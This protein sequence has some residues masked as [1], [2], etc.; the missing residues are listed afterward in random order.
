[1]LKRCNSLLVV[2]IALLVFAGLVFAAEAEKGKDPGMAKPTGND[3][4]NWFTI[5]NLFN[6]YV[7]NGNSS[8]NWSTSQSGLEYPKGSEIHPIFEDGVVWGGFHKGRST[9][10]VGGSTYRYALQ[11]GTIKT[12]GTA[13]TDPVADDPTLAKFRV[14]KVRPDVKPTTAFASVKAAMD[15]EAALI[16]RYQSISAS[17]LFAQYQKDWNEWP[18]IEG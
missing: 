6:W 11:A 9:P 14:Y 10:K 12:L 7:N 18:A 2:A 13:T 16:S 1:M 8:Y 17:A 3:N 4:Q 5:N 15:E